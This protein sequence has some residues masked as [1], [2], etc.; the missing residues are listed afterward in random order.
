M[1]RKREKE[2]RE[3]ENRENRKIEVTLV[4]ESKLLSGPIHLSKIMTNYFVLHCVQ[5][6][7]L[8]PV[9]S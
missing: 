5:R 7:W 2:E 1:E 8:D 4:D 6:S 9:V 3:R